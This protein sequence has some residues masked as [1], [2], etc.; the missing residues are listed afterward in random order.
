MHSGFERST[1]STAALPHN[2]RGINKRGEVNRALSRPVMIGRHHNLHRIGTHRGRAQIA[3]HVRRLDKPNVCVTRAN[4]GDDL[5]TVRRLLDLTPRIAGM[6]AGGATHE[7]AQVVAIGGIIG[8]GALAAADV[9]KLAR[10]LMLAPVIAILSLRQRRM[11]RASGTESQR[12][13]YPPVVPLFVIGF[14]AMVLLRSFVPLP[15]EVVAAGGAIQTTL[16]AAAMFALGLGVRVHSL[17]AVGVRPFVLAALSTA[18]VTGI[19]FVGIA[20]SA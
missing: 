2:E 10:V 11:S 13:T 4:T 16:L 1:G 12:G 18:I 5:L 17:I 7:V 9:V 8:G 3:R 20:L 19:A 6:W 15:D 14:V